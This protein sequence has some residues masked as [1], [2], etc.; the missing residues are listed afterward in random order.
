VSPEFGIRI[1]KNMRKEEE[2]YPVIK[3]ALNEFLIT[4]AEVNIT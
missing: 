3:A 4:R 1:V 2:Y